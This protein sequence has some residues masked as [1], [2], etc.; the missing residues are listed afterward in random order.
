MASPP[1]TAARKVALD[2]FLAP[3]TVRRLARLVDLLKR[4]EIAR[5]VGLKGLRA[6]ID[7]RS[8]HGIALLVRHAVGILEGER[9]T[10]QPKN[11]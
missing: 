4:L 1:S 2:V 5:P 10:G 8:H 11:E 7:F 3:S 6:G 9:E